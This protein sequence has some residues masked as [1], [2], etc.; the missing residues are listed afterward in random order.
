MIS[1]TEQQREWPFLRMT[2]LAVLALLGLQLLGTVVDKR[3]HPAPT[4]LDLTAKCLRNEKRL[5]VDI[6]ATDPIAKTA[7]GG[8]LHTRVERNGVTI[9]T[10]SS[11]EKAKRIAGY[12]ATVNPGPED[13]VELKGHVV[14]VWEFSPLLTQRQT[15]Y[16]CYY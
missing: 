8:A 16:D 10:S 5:A 11:D 4:A 15:T 9:V 1:A 3:I 7:D 12:Y 2:L 13:V 14:Y 6:G